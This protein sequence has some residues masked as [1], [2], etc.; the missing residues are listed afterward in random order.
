MKK[1]TFQDIKNIADYEKIRKSSIASVIETKKQRRISLGEKM[2]LVFENPMTV[3]SQIQEMM[4]AERI[5]EEANIQHEIDVYNQ[6]LPDRDNE[7]RA[8][9]FIEITDPDAIKHDL[10]KMMGIDSS[11]HIYFQVGSQQ[12]F[13]Q[14]EGGHSNEIKLSAVHY[15]TFMF[16]SEQFSAFKNLDLPAYLISNHPNYKAK[17][18]LETTV[19]ESLV[20]DLGL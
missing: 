9:L 19:R 6:L 5:V 3:L 4:R 18:L 11:E 7:L 16:D 20:H 8:T 17:V 13:A 1:V 10:D 15:R 12:I 14:F 2:S